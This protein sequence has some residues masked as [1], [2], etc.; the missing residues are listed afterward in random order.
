[1]KLDEEAY[2]NTKFDSSL[3][4]LTPILDKNIN[5][6]N[7]I[8][9][10]FNVGGSKKN[11][12]EIIYDIALVNLSV[13]C[14]LLSPYLKWKLIKNNN[15]EF[16]GSLDYRFDTIKDNRLVLTNIQQD[17]I[18]YNEDKTVYDHYD[19]YMWI[20]D[21][22]QEEDITLCKSHEEQTNL[23]NKVLSGKIEVELYGGTKT[24][25]VR[26]PREE[27]NTSTCIKKDGD[28]NE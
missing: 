13:D 5:D 15:E 16:T 9:I 27:L 20:S 7:S 26:E 23:L 10:K 6:N 25:V 28:V 18:P 17:L 21:S 1:M 19:F 24:N 14:E 11:N 2:G 4:K 22:C 8:H 3:T 12:T